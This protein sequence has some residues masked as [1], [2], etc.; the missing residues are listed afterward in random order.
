MRDL[1]SLSTS[2]TCNKGCQARCRVRG[3]ICE[4]CFSLRD[5]GYKGG[6]KQKLEKNHEILT[7]QRLDTTPYLFSPSGYFRIEAFGDLEN[8]T[9][10][11][12][13]LNIIKDNKHLRFAWFT[14]VPEIIGQALK[15]SGMEKPKNVK[16]IASSLFVN[17]SDL[18]RFK[19]LEYVDHVFTV[20][21]A[22]FIKENNINITCGARSCASCGKCYEKKYKEYEIREKLK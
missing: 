8:V 9:Q 14:K 22:G 20:Y 10:A 1:F 19:K 6:L 4:K 21:N 7:T 5:C 3:S 12:N 15:E 2:P 13:Y 18:E 17:V 16:I 11:I